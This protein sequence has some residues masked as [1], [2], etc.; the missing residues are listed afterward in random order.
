MRDESK[1]SGSPM[2][3]DDVPNKWER[4]YTPILQSF[5]DELQRIDSSHKGMIPSALIKYLLGRY[6]FYKIITDDKIKAEIQK[7][8]LISGTLNQPS[9]KEKPIAKAAL[10]KMPKQFY[11]IGFKSQNTI[12]VV[13]DEGWQISMRIHSASSKVEPSLKFD[14]NLI[15]LPSSVHTQ[16][17][18][19]DK[20]V[21]MKNRMKLYSSIH[22]NL[23]K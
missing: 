18:P 7:K 15:S 3:W 11:H 19:W 17:E 13:C 8:L 2:L 1:Q 4:Y 5:V 16:T 23:C 12:E 14:V 9:G 6:D 22:E 21:R 20:S 10:L